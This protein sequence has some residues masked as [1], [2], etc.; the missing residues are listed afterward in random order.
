MTNI[1]AITNRWR[2]VTTTD[3]LK[4]RSCFLFKP[5]NRFRIM[6]YN[7]STSPLFEYIILVAI[8][9][10]CVILTQQD[11]RKYIFTD[12][13]IVADF[14]LNLVFVMEALIKIISNGFVLHRNAYLRD[15]W[16]VFDFIVVTTGRANL[17]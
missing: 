8:I 17:I 14:S 11:G 7:I 2:L 13:I 3:K 15:P 4:H 16:N 12:P 10:S 1:L 6:L 9:A 5:D